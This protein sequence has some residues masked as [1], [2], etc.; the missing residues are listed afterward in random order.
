MRPEDE[1]HEA[2]ARAL[3][4]LVMPPAEWTTFPA[5]HAKLPPAVAAKL[6]R[7]GLK[8]GIPDILVWHDGRSCGIELKRPGGVLSK[9]RM[10][11][12]KR[13]GALRLVEGQADVFPRL[14]A[15]GMRIAVCRSVDEVLAALRGWG[16]PLRPYVMTVAA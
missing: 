2:V 12:T 10:V 1:L 15:A 8:R 13:R 3:D 4:I 6:A 5:G 16:V 14:V 7:L 9:T 11:R